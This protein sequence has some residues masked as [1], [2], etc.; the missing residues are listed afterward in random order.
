MEVRNDRESD[1]VVSLLLTAAPRDS[2]ST[3]L[4]VD[5]AGAAAE[6]WASLSRGDAAESVVI[7]GSGR[8]EAAEV[9]IYGE[10]FAAR[11]KTETC[12]YSWLCERTR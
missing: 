2:D 3:P 8:S 7:G 10:E 1:V 9:G 11:S 12:P 5:E 4:S 6:F